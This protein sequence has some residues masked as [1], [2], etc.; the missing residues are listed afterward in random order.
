MLAVHNAMAA[1]S[2]AGSALRLADAGTGTPAPFQQ[3]DGKST[4][5]FNDPFGEIGA[6][7]NC[8]GVLAIGGFCTSAGTSTVE[9]VAFQR[10]TEGDLTINDGFGGC[11]YWNAT[12]LAEVITHELGHTI[13]L[14]HS[15]EN[16][17][18]SDAILKDDRAHFD[19]RGATLRGAGVQALYPMAAASDQDDD[20]V[21]DSSDDCPGV[22]NAD[23]ADSDHDG[24]GDACDP[25]RLRSFTLDVVNRD[26]LVTALI[27]F[28]VGTSFEPTRD[29]L[30]VN[31][32][33]ERGSL[34]V[35]TVRA[36]SMR[37][38]VHSP[39]TYSARIA[40]SD[41]VGVVSFTR[42]RNGSGTFVLRASSAHFPQA[43][44]S[45][46]VL[47]LTFGQR[48]FVKKLILERTETGTWV[49]P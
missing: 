45:R 42:Q 49:C 22:P 35:G 24:I 34:Y 13:G 7:S 23:Q 14:G 20:G 29:G 19:G 21:P 43:T 30:A 39:L 41:G 46:T 15:S 18:E 47:S 2:G 38:A 1:W 25:V 31:L 5:Q 17:K 32:S 44:G 11:R 3:C 4:I 36:R 37:R 12:N 9:G 8:G 27:R 40:S 33:D 26:V 16:P 28:P 10:I 6:P 48:T